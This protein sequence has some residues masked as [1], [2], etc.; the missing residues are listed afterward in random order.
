[1]KP[2]WTSELGLKGLLNMSLY[3]DIVR[4]VTA[5]PFHPRANTQLCFSVESEQ[6]L[7]QVTGIKICIYF[8][9]KKTAIR[10]V[11]DQRAARQDL[12][13]ID[14]AWPPASQSY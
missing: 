11:T 14:I 9:V 13:E 12:A 8:S 2:R 5:L 3:E 4:S 10:L 7:E 6:L 1:M